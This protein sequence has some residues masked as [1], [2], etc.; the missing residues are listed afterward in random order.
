MSTRIARR[1]FLT[2][3]CA[4][5][6]VVALPLS[7]ARAE[8]STRVFSIIRDGDDVGRHSVRMTRDGDLCD[9][10][11]DVE[12]AIKVLGI[13]AYRYTMANRERWRA[14][15]LESFESRVDDDGD[16]SVTRAERRDGAL[17]VEGRNFS[18]EAPSDAVTTTYFTMDFLDRGTWI[19]TDGGE[20]F[21]IAATEL[22]AVSAAEAWS[23]RDCTRWRARATNDDSYDVRLEYDSRG[24]WVG[25]AFDAGGEQAIYRPDGDARLAALWT[26]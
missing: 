7:P 24:E 13:T 19:S 9:V 2:G 17:I 15:L 20:L 12:I 8:S 14:G 23:G 18:G 16:E 21:T 11:I 26:G 22:G 10:A 4:G 6:A 25:L 5:A 1:P 3:V